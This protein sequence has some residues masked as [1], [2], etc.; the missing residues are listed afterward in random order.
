VFNTDIAP[1]T[2]VIGFYNRWQMPYA[3]LIAGF[4][5]F[6]QFLGYNDN[7][8]GVFLRR[9]W[10]PLLVS[11]ALTVPFA[12]WGVVGH[13]NMLV[14]VFFILF[15]IISSVQNMLFQTVK[16]RNWAAI[17]THIGFAFFLLGTVLTFSNSKVISSNT[18][19]YD[20]GDEQLNKENLMLV[21]NDTVYMSGYY[22]AYVNDR[23]EGNT[24]VY[25]V[26]FM[27]YRNGKYIKEFTLHPS[28]NIHPRMGAVYN[29]DTRHFLGRDYYSYI[30][31]V[32]PENQ[33][34]VI[35]AILNPYINV[36]W[37]GSVVMVSG[38]VYAFWRRARRRWISNT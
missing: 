29:P 10:L 13:L 8:A 22:V 4:I 11:L 36:L 18:S 12:I 31:T 20:L 6:S 3:M 19:K 2:D 5:A 30:A 14:F 24:T 37:F 32:G 1:P 15:A 17:I 25:Q 28:V 23:K 35:K 9:I 33:Y 34:I 16:P 38:F 7:G 27:K 26:E 21:R